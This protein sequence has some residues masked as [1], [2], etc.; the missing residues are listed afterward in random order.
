MHTLT[1]ALIQCMAL[2]HAKYG[3]IYQ[4]D[5]YNILYVHIVSEKRVQI[6][7]YTLH[8]YIQMKN[9][10]LIERGQAGRMFVW[11][12]DVN[13]AQQTACFPFACTLCM[14]I[15]S[16]QNQRGL[17]CFQITSHWTIQWQII[18]TMHT[19]SRI[20][21]TLFP[22]QCAFFFFVMHFTAHL[23]HLSLLASSLSL[24]RSL[25]ISRPFFV[26]LL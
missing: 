9:N 18:C 8:T 25:P 6:E 19:Y 24:C 26:C 16:I 21:M 14:C 15:V 2:T 7:T 12:R 5:C 13:S 4:E 3:F 1:H 22:V 11:S 23:K 20:W 17:K 10:E